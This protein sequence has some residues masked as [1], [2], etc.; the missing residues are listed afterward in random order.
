MTQLILALVAAFGLGLVA[1]RLRLPPLLGFLAA[2][3]VLKAAG[4]AEPVGI[5]LVSDVGVVLLLF[6]IGLKLDPKTLLRREIW[7]TT[8]IHLV[9]TVAIVVGVLTAVAALG[10]GILSDEDVRTYALLG[11]AV[12]FSST[13]LAVK[14]LEARSQTASVRPDD[15][16]HP[17]RP[18]CRRRH[19]HHA[20]P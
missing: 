12:S 10:L 3:F 20:H 15:D 13:M 7:I 8:G 6:G 9:V 19:L 5:D 18:G 11:F 4:M 1:E 16:R 17:R 2:G 14:M